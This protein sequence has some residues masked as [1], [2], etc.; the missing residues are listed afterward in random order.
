MY[1]EN[2]FNKAVMS[3]SSNFLISIDIISTNVK[4]MK[5]AK[6]QFYN[7]HDRLVH[8]IAMPIK[9]YMIMLF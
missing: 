8:P 4:S 6:S 2:L 9:L 3:A 1:C 5:I 7:L